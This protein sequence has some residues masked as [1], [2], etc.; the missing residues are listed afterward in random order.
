MGLPT[1]LRTIAVCQRCGRSA[2][3]AQAL[4][5]EWLVARYRIDPGLWV[6]RCYGCISEWSLRVSAAGRTKVWRDRMKRGRERLKKEPPWANP[7]LSPMSSME[8]PPEMATVTLPDDSRID[9]GPWI[10]M[11]THRRN[12]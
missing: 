12:K 11:N 8:L 2:T 10:E 4:S 3:M 9:Y 5:D 6:I 1:Q 7:M